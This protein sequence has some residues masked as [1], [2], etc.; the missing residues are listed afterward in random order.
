[1]NFEKFK[2]DLEINSLLWAITFGENRYAYAALII[3]G[4]IEFDDLPKTLYD[5]LT[6]D[7]VAFALMQLGRKDLITDPEYQV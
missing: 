6:R 3:G 7:E 2:E 5:P 1:M 4:V